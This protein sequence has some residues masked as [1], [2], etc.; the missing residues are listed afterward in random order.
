MKFR[1]FIKGKVT[2]AKI[3]MINLPAHGHVN[4]TLA[5][6][7]ELS[8]R[9][10]EVSYLISEEF[11]EEI[12]ATGAKVISYSEKIKSMSSVE[13]LV[14]YVPIIYDMALKI[15]INYDC[16]IYEMIFY[17]GKQLGYF[18]NKPTVHL[19]STFAI[20][21]KMA[22]AVPKSTSIKSK[23]IEFYK[24]SLID[25]PD[26]NLVYTSKEFQ[27][28]SEQFDHNI[29]KFVGPSISKRII[30]IDIPFDRLKETV[31]YISFG[32]IINISPDFFKDC[33]KAF[34][35]MEVTVI[36]SVGKRI[37]ID[38]LGP[39]PDNFL[40]Y[41]SVPQLEILKHSD[42]FITHG[43]M[44]SVHEAMYYGIPVIAIPQCADQPIVAKRLEQ[45]ML[46]KVLNKDEISA[47]CLRSTVNEILHNSTY[48]RN[49]LRMSKAM[50][51]AGGYKTSA[52][53]IENYIYNKRTMDK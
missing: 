34:S 9:C 17:M 44:N 4:P 3:L 39:I 41:P 48:R 1:N 37:Y 53:E 49:M 20:N 25:V 42:V 21:E 10:H 5:L 45:L 43:G 16:I 30:K 29:F 47:E 28:H 7:R 12:E 32:T 38:A 33:V 31:I 24:K 46:G 26:L 8:N 11:R 18:L 14:S 6:A 23:L 27:V 36:M 40:V 52:D 35:D 15:G 2:M 50:I 22:N 51:S 19:I 13:G